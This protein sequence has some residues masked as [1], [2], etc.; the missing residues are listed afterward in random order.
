MQLDPP[1][2][3]P[4]TTSVNDASGIAPF[5]QVAA[6]LRGALRVGEFDVGERLPS[7]REL[8]AQYDVSLTTAVRAMEELRREGLIETRRGRGSYVRARPVLIRA[9]S[10][11]YLRKNSPLGGTE[12]TARTGSAEADRQLARRLRVEVGDE[13]SVVHYF[14]RTVDGRPL[15]MSTQ[16]EPL[17][18]TRGTP[19]EE[20][21]TRAGLTVIERFDSIGIHVDHVDEDISTRMPSATESEV[22]QMTPGTPVFEIIRTHWASRLAVETATIVIRGDRMVIATTHR[23]PDAGEDEQC[24]A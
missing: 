12:L 1:P 17:T 10:Q 19:V 3:T 22:L 7:S 11:R 21:A 18:L 20:P 8:A 23:V 4:D 16:W 6:A 2:P 24:P 15:Q 13:L 5:R 14:W 9:G